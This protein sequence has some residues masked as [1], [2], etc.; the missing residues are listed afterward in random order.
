MLVN[1]DVG[2][3]RSV[4]LHRLKRQTRM[5]TGKNALGIYSR[6][7]RTRFQL[8]SERTRDEMRTWRER[9]ELSGNEVVE[10]RNS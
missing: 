10:L 5:R 2:N 6:R 7:A 4:D 9:G 1:V 3:L 8:R